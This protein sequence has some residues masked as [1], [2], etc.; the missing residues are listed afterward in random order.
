METVSETR[1]KQDG[2]ES[3]TFKTE[4]PVVL[5]LFAHWHRKH[6]QFHRP[7]PYARFREHVP[8]RA[9]FRKHQTFADWETASIR[10]YS[11]S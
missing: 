7:F 11:C 6:P 5:H 8:T 3:R 9:A 2:N 1:R 10:Q 4:S